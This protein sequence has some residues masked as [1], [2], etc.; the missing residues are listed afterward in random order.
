MTP[1]YKVRLHVIC[2]RRVA[3]VA[4]TSLPLVRRSEDARIL[5]TAVKPAV[6]CTYTYV[7]R[8]VVI[9]QTGEP[10][11]VHPARLRRLVIVV[12]RLLLFLFL[13]CASFAFS[14]RRLSLLTPHPARPILQCMYSICPTVYLL[15]HVHNVTCDVHLRR[16][17]SYLMLMAMLYGKKRD[18]HYVYTYQCVTCIVHD[19]HIIHMYCIQGVSFQT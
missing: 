17:A 18:R 5:R 16:V 9:F 1:M 8:V 3:Y 6:T 12:D 7:R 11:S 19:I 14:R 13:S 15:V 10:C 2:V 4:Y